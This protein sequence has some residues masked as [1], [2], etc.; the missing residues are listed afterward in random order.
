MDIQIEV[1]GGVLHSNAAERLLLFEPTPAFYGLLGSGEDEDLEH[2][3]RDVAHH[4]PVAFHLLGQAPSAIY[5]APRDGQPGVGGRLVG[6]ATS[7][8][9]IQ[10]PF[11]LIGESKAIGAVIAHELGHHVL[12]MAHHSA[13]DYAEN[14]A[15]TD[16]TCVVVGLGKLLLNGKQRALSAHSPF[17]QSLGH[18]PLDLTTY[19]FDRVCDRRGVG[20]DERRRNLTPQSLA[21]FD[22]WRKGR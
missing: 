14:E 13:P 11:G 10:V 21:A 3:V 5:L 17:Q 12:M 7:R 6:G 20:R 19:A 15:I 9:Q 18:L 2:A 22:S 8:P 16:L 4:P 1:L